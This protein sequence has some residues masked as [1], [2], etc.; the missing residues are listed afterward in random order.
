MGVLPH[1]KKLDDAPGHFLVQIT[2]RRGA[3]PTAEP[4]VLV[5]LCGSSAI[6]DA[7]GRRMRGSKCGTKNAEVL[8]ALAGCDS[9]PTVTELADAAGIS[10]KTASRTLRVLRKQGRAA[11]K[12]DLQDSRLK[13]VALTKA[14]ESATAII[15]SS[16]VQT[17]RRVVALV[18]RKR[19]G[20]LSTRTKALAATLV[21]LHIRGRQADH[22]HGSAE[23]RVPPWRRLR[24]TSFPKARPGIQKPLNTLS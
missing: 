17:A 14:G 12:E 5:R 23:Q 1:I 4:E 6:L 18:A 15:A 24:P 11:L 9:E 7:A 8:C 13:R 21:T 16:F 20:Y 22:G 10:L 19:D 2:C 3:Q